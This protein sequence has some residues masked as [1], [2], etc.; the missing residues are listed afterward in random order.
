M[1]F[2]VKEIRQKNKIKEERKKLSWHSM[3]MTWSFN[4]KCQNTLPKS[5]S[6]KWI[7]QTCR[8]KSW[9]ASLIYNSMKT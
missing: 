2:L 3:Q 1:E 9:H 4:Q 6:N 7:R 8:I 5:Y